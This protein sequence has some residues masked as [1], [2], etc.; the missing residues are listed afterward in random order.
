MLGYATAC[1][2]LDT[3]PY[4]QVTGGNMWSS[5]S[6]VEKGVTGVYTSLKKPIYSNGMVGAGLWVGYYGLDVLGMSGSSRLAMNG[7]FTSSINPG[8]SYFSDTWKWCYDGVHRANAAIANIPSANM[9]EAKKAKRLAE[10]KVL[11]AFFYGRLNELFGNGGLGVPIYLEPIAADECIRSQSPEADVWN[12]IITDLTEAI[13]EPN[14]P[15]NDIGGEGRVSKGCAYALRGRAYLLTQQ[16]DLAAN[17]F[18]KVKDCGYELYTSAGDQSYKQ[19]FKEANERCKEMILNIQ[20]IEEPTK[21]YGS[22]L[23][24]YVAAFQQG[25]ED[26]RGCWSDIR[27]APAVVDLYEVVNGATVSNF[28]YETYFPGWNSLS[29]SDR[30][31]FF[32]RDRYKDGVEIQPGT[33]SSTISGAINAIYNA[34]SDAAKALYLSEGNEARCQAAYANRDPRLAFNVITPYAEFLGVNSTSTAEGLYVYRWPV[35]GK[36]YVDQAGAKPE[37]DRGMTPTGTAN[38]QAELV[39]MHRKFVGE[40]LDFAYRESNPIDE[41]IIRYADVLLLWA[42][43]LVE[44]NDLPGAK[45]KV[46]E[47]RDRAGIVT[48]DAPFANQASARNYVRDERRREF[49]GEGI[50]FFDEMRW[51]TLKETKFDRKFVEQV[52]G[53]QVSTGGTYNWIGDQWY[54][55]PVPRT[56]IERNPNLKPTPGWIYN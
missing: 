36:Y 47:V 11:R 32:L 50:N 10:C 9:D 54:T 20:Y 49:V 51:R 6:L 46:K 23:Q 29:V 33:A 48:P 22:T 40:G 52:H 16:Y 41:P 7:L 43:A 25:S 28:D 1:V 53:G 15:N 26:S 14:L 27:I 38:A 3:A 56:E 34:L 4:A 44:K 30:R 21:A 42:E 17:D 45:A 37:I 24:K 18:A 55:W 19:L 2:D 8:N 35:G 31:V 13:N 12:Q 5:E 39:Y